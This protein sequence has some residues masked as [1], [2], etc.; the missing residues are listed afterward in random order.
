[1]ILSYET[2][3][4]TDNLE[5]NSKLCLLSLFFVIQWLNV[6]IVKDILLSHLPHLKLFSIK[7]PMMNVL[8]ERGRGY[9]CFDCSNKC[10][11]WFTTSFS[12]RGIDLN[13][14]RN[15]WPKSWFQHSTLA[16]KNILSPFIF[17]LYEFPVTFHFQFVLL[18]TN[19]GGVGVGSLGGFGIY[20]HWGK[21]HGG[22]DDLSSLEI[23]T[24]WNNN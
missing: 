12:T 1:M 19:L 2:Y 13:S 10:K 4:W 22:G 20:G 3:L 24:N 23:I 14:R 11:G 5:K 21:Q 7:A 9:F 17:K 6:E 18:V 16:V 8:Q 15:M